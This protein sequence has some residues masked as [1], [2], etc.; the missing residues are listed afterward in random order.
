[1]TAAD[2]PKTVLV[3]GGTGVFGSRLSERLLR[4]L[5]IRLVVAGR[6]RRKAEELAARLRANRPGADVKGVSLPIDA[7]LQRGIAAIAPFIVM[8][9]A[10]PFQGQDY[11]VAEAALAAGAHYIDLSDGREFV[12]GFSR[13]D[14]VAKEK[15]LVALTGASSVPALSSVVIGEFA[16]EMDRVTSIDFGIAPGNRTERG[17]AV[18][19]AALGYCGRPIPGREGGRPVTRYGWGGSRRETLG[20]AGRRWFSDCDIPDLDI[21][22]ALYP[23]ASIRFGAG[24]ELSVMHFGLG[25]LSALARWRLLPRLDLFARPILF[26]SRIFTPFGSDVGGMYVRVEGTAGG[27]GVSRH[28]SLVARDGHGPYVPALPAAIMARRLLEGKNPPSGAYACVGMFGLTDLCAEAEGL[29]VEWGEDVP[30]SLFRRVAGA[31]FDLMPEPVR[32]VHDVVEATSSSGTCRVTHGTNALA[33]L[34]A[35]AM[36]MPPAAE[37]APAAVTIRREGDAEVWIRSIGGSRFQSTFRMVAPG[38]LSETLG[39]ARFLFELKT[40]PEGFAFLIA[41]FRFLGIPVPRFLRPEIGAGETASGSTSVF[42][43]SGRVPFIG[44]IVAY[45]GALQPDDAPQDERPGLPVMLFD[46]VCNFC[47]RGVDFFLRRDPHARIR[48]AAMQSARG[49]ELLRKHDLPL[50]DYRTFI[51]LD[52][53]RVIAKS[54]AVLHLLGYLP[55]PWPALRIFRLVPAIIRNAAYDIVARNRYSLMGRREVC[56]VPGE[57]E[58][59]RFLI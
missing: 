18:M 37:A 59:K 26:A 24:L 46:G 48:F 14:A 23:D 2:A 21:L 45:R 3:L 10:G 25:A 1:M 58:R 47:N 36:R 31:D 12:S 44:L 41:G 52:G 6:D 51:V 30:R 7:H 13:L 33:R 50:D 56:R 27:H 53:E 28:W 35:W 17:E 19:R 39:P 57:A 29:S 42:D 20:D 54:D 40:G 49:I 34:L 43:V 5:G 16:R 38:L 9:A 32:R 4:N 55:W 11:A 15:G 8:H 22:P